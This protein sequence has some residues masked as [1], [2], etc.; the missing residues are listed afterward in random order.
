MCLLLVK[1]VLMSSW[2]STESFTHYLLPA[3]WE[4]KFSIRV[5][6]TTS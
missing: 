6:F 5:N 3:Y 1:T 2:N 4:E